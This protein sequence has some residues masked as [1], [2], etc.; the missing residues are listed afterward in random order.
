M[1]SI[2]FHTLGCKLNQLETESIAEAFKKEGFSLVEW[3]RPADIFVVN[4]CTVTSKAEQK[5]RRMI[6]KALR[7]NP[8]ACLIA[9]GCYAQLDGKA[10]EG[11]SEDGRIFVVAGELKAVL[12]DLPAYLMDHGCTSVDIIPL[13]HRWMADRLVASE[14]HEQGQKNPFRFNVQDYSFHSRAFL[15]IQDG[16]N[17]SCAFCRVRLARGRSESLSAQLVL[18][19]LQQLEA[20]GFAEAVLTGVNLHQY[21]DGEID[22]TALLEYLLS[23]TKTIALRISSTEPDGVDGRFAAVF[24]HPRI[25]PHI[26][27]SVQSGSN[28][29]LQKMRRRYRAEQVAEAVAR[30]RLAKGDPFIACDII[31]G[32]PGETDEDFEETYELCKAL[33]FSFIH[34]FPYSPRPGT[35]AYTMQDRVSESLSGARLERL[36]TLAEQGKASYVTRWIGRNVS[37]IVEHHQA[38]SAPIVVTENY[39]KARLHIP[40]GHAVPEAK[41]SLRCKLLGRE[42]ID[43][44]NMDRE[45]SVDLYAELR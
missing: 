15:K 5:A 43:I 20:H 22:F 40:E 24:A 45:D 31:T 21:K 28:R 37:A 23:G 2:S 14:A 4:T 44:S 32:F 29:I 42:S 9:T 3:G 12:L 36:L 38:G 34:A 1:L 8:A 10:L 11:L 39:L 41:Q 19:R 27:L 16:C 13:M 35:E 30:L 26:H 7:D 6:R 18:E 33:D 17:N 25:R